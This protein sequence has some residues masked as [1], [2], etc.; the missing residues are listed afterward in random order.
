MGLSWISWRTTLT[1][2]ITILQ[3]QAKHNQWVSEGRFSLYDNTTDGFFIVTM[4][5]LV[6]ED[7][8][9]YWCGVDVTFFPDHISVIQLNVS[10]E[11]NLPL[12]LTAVIYVTAMLFVCVFTL[13]LLLAVKHQRSG[14]HQN[15]ET[16]ADYETMMLG[17]RSE[18]ELHSS[19]LTPDC[20]D[21]SASSPPPTDLCSLFTTKHQESTVTVGLGEY[22]DVDVPGY[23]CQ[24]QRLDLSQSEEHVYQ[25]LYENSSPKDGPLAV[26][27]QINC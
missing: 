14:P 9:T 22:V 11:Y 3:I 19:C 8:G 4:S 12:F 20:T 7:S 26:K 24:Y 10:R 1:V 23:I 13:C 5:K 2:I 16:S 21:L 17:V 6:P 27:E 25:S 15:R 18:P